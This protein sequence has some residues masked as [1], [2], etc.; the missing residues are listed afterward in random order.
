MP[1]TKLCE[2]LHGRG[3]VRPR[4]GGF[5]LL[6]CVLMFAL[7]ATVVNRL[8]RERWTPVSGR[9]T[10]TATAY[11]VDS[12]TGAKTP[13]TFTAGDPQRAA[14]TANEVAESYAGDRV[15]QWRHGVERRRVKAHE[16]AEKTRQEYRESQVRL[17]AFKRQL[18]EAAQ[19]HA[20]AS[21]PEKRQPTMIENP[22][23]ADLSRR[24][25]DLER[26]HEQLLQ[27]RTPLHPA[28]LEITAHLTEAQEQLAAVPRQIAGKESK[29]SSADNSPV[30]V[31][32]RI[33]DV[34]AS[35]NQRAL[36]DL[37]AAVEQS[38]LACR[39]AERRQQQTAE[40]QRAGPQLVIE[41]AETAQNAPQVDYGW[42][43][44]LWT[45][46]ATSLLMAFGVGSVAA[47]AR[48]EP[49]V[50]SIE[51]VKSAL[52]KS[53]IGVM[54]ADTPGLDA[55]AIGRQM[56]ARRATMAIGLIMIVACPVVA[57]WGVMGI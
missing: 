57:I 12:Q 30:L 8:G 18:C 54:P 26:R 23:W 6:L 4:S 20:D 2:R 56:Q 3:T 42:R 41:S 17:D 1:I 31:P 29:T 33:D 51:E 38:R 11:A 10:Y 21:R 34:A 53:V 24:A 39:S 52:G 14:E 13:F 47:G 46:F 49:P 27:D 28:V 36:D 44:L 55:T 15:A 7:T 32:P 35:K 50:A 5:P 40:Q 9:P 16:S 37:T 48:I 19:A 45:T 43:R 25:S 22:R